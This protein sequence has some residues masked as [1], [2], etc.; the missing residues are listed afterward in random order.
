M[1]TPM[2]KDEFKINYFQKHTQS[3]EL[4][5]RIIGTSK[6]IFYHKT[7][8]EFIPVEDFNFLMRR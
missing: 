2:D 4:F 5:N 7:S 6:K 1:F 3:S 8:H